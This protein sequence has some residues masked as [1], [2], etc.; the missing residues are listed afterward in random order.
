MIVDSC[1][2]RRVPARSPHD[3]HA[4]LIKLYGHRAVIVRLPQ[5]DGTMI[6]R[7]PC[8]VSTIFRRVYIGHARNQEFSSRGRGGGVQVNLTK[9]L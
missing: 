2:R 9:K 3:A 4:G 5:G 6:V 8:D 1:A 7:S